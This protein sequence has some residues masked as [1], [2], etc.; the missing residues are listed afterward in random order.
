[1]EEFKKRTKEK[2][3]FEIVE[4][5]GDGL[6]LYRCMI[7]FLVDYQKELNHH[8]CFYKIFN[9]TNIKEIG[10]SINLQ[11]MLKDWILEHKDDILDSSL[12]IEG[13]LSDLVMIDHGEYVDSIETY[14]DLY[15][16]PANEVSHFN[17]KETGETIFMPMR[18]GGVTE[19]YA[20]SKIFHIK[21]YQW[22][23]KRWNVIKSEIEGC[24]GKDRGGRFEI[25]QQ[26]QREDVTGIIFDVLYADYGFQA[27]HY[28]Y[29][30]NKKQFSQMKQKMK[31]F[32]EKNRRE[33]REEK[34]GNSRDQEER[35]EED[36]ETS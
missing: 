27:R 16:I 31:V 26:I 13:T 11:M 29:L 28:S 22:S 33:K 24:D 4:V 36:Y 12:P 30:R 20:F 34:D 9:D 15:S 7:R 1:M 25:I 18:W 8:D 23:C 5:N 6:C 17:D 21:V 35:K 3:D 2:R 19:I 10:A 32:K 14:G